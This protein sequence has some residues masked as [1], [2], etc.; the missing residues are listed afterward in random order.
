M[1]WSK[2]YRCAPGF[3]F[4]KESFGGILFHYEGRTPDPR[5]CFVDSRFLI[6]LLELVERA[7]LESLMEEATATFRLGN[8]QISAMRRFF[9][10][11]VERKAL[12]PA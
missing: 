1:D 4:R 8:S 10:D 7:P 3:A 5:L 9:G 11:L 2:T 12:V 6:D